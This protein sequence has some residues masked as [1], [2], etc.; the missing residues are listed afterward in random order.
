[1][2]KALRTAVLVIGA[3]ALVATGIGAAA[4][5]GLFGAAAAAAGGTVAGISVAT[6]AAIGT[7]ASLA[8][9]VLGVVAQ[10]TAPKPSA[11]GS[12]TSFTTNPQSGLPY[13]MGRCRMSGLRIYAKTRSSPNWSKTHDLLFF[14]VLLTIGGQIDS[15]EKFTGDNEV[16]TFD[17]ST[18]QATSGSHPDWMAQKVHLG[19]T[20]TSALALSLISGAAPGWTGDH[21]LSGMTHALWALRAD[22]KNNEHFTGGVPEPA[23]IGKWVRVYDPRL[24][25]TYPGGSGACRALDESTYV[26]SQNPGLHALTW[27]LG[28]WQNGKRTCGIG[29]PIA[30]IRV[31][32]F[33]EC[34]NVCDANGWKVGGVEW[35]TDSKWDSLKRILQAGGAIPTQTGAMIGCLVATPRVAIATIESRH[36]LERL[37]IAKTKPRTQRFN[38]VIPRFVDEASEWGLVAGAPI[39]E[40]AFVT[41]DGGPRTKG[42]D[43]PLVPVFDGEA[44]TQPGQLSAYAI[45]NSREA[46]PISWATGPEFAGLK[47]GDVVNLNVP[48]KDLNNQPVLITRRSP[49][50]ATGMIRF[51]ADTETYSKHAYALGQATTPP[52]PFISTPPD[53]TPE[54]PAGA[55]WA[56]TPVASGSGEPGL[57]VTGTADNPAAEA[58]VM[59]YRKVGD[60]DW[61]PSG[62]VPAATAIRHIITGLLPSTDYE[63]RIGYRTSGVTGAFVELLG[64]Y[65]TGAALSGSYQP[66]SGDLTAIDAL[67]TTSFGRGYLVLGDAAAG[68]GYIGAV[69]LAGDT[70]TGALAVHGGVSAIGDGTGANVFNDRYSTNASSPSY[71]TRKARGSLASPSAVV[72]NDIIG[73]SVFQGYSGAA[74]VTGADFRVSVVATTPSATDMESIVEFRACASGSASLTN[75]F[76]YSAGGIA[77]SVTNARTLGTSALLWSESWVVRRY[78]T[79]TVFDAF[80]SGSPEGVVTAG[81]GS[82]YR[83]T[84]G[85]A[86]TSFYVKESGTGNTGWVAK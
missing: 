69:N 56:V 29:A 35:T 73:N 79:S 38:T 18:G 82:T 12:S 83:R 40:P 78:Y 63:V 72:Q 44:A 43:F 71:L 6:I 86:G 61:L 53:L 16:I 19:T 21:K 33:V 55:D 81:I 60:A 15:I 37:T 46:G 50:P 52:P 9:G 4:G 80:G 67:T 22:T 58:V 23:W 64:P 8:A 30:N 68:R 41:Q 2:A 10:L 51:S 49:D 27:S 42:I 77:P 57:I 11:A 26:W 84:N 28:R 34:A 17:A 32:D 70:M 13:A 66:L 76:R 74:F 3:V 7:W 31:A 14:G 1:M 47:T 85:G 25:S 54:A 75:V 36:L 24:D 5:A 45:V 20:M 48:E 39:V 65:A 59:E 62:T